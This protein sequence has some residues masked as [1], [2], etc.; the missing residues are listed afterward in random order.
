MFL[1][2]IYHG[3]RILA[4]EVMPRHLV[5]SCR[6]FIREM[7]GVDIPRDIFIAV[8]GSD[9]VRLP[10]GRFAVLEDNLRVP[11]GVSYMLVNLE[12]TRS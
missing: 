2:D 10:D 12:A 9:L 8:V 11:S 7:Q 1:H 6:H 5:Y 4:Q 3:A